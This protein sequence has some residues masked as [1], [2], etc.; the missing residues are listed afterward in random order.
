MWNHHVRV[1]FFFWNRYLGKVEIFTQ[2]IDFELPDPPDPTVA[3]LTYG[4]RGS[5][6]GS[7]DGYPGNPKPSFFRAYNPYFQG[8]KASFQYFS[9]DP[10]L[11]F[12]IPYEPVFWQDPRYVRIK[13]E[14]LVLSMFIAGQ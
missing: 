9:R 7:N 2:Q 5:L 11:N 12:I 1:Y 3:P 6:A 14:L 8:F 4:T 10:L 13:S